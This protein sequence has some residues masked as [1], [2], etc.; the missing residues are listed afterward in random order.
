MVS[1]RIYMNRCTKI[2]VGILAFLLLGASVVAQ[3]GNIE[4]YGPVERKRMTEYGLEIISN[5]SK[6]IHEDKKNV[7]LYKERATKFFRLIEVNFDN[8]SQD[9]Y[10]DKYEADLSWI[11]ELEPT[12]ENYIRRGSF[13]EHRLRIS[14]VPQEIT[15]LYPK[16]EY[17]DRALDDLTKAISITSDSQE[18]MTAYTY[19]SGLYIRRPRKLVSSPKLSEFRKKVDLKKVIEELENAIRS[20][21]R[22]LEESRETSLSANLISIYQESADIAARLGLYE[23]AFRF[24][25][26]GGKYLGPWTPACS[27]LSAWGGL[28]L[29]LNEPEKAIDK[30]RSISLH[31]QSRCMDLYE[32]RGDVYVEMGEYDLALSDY[33]EALSFDPNDPFRREGKVYIKRALLFFKMGKT[34]E[35]LNDLGKALEKEYIAECPQA[36]RIRAEVYL[37]LKKPDLAKRDEQTAAKLKD[38]QNCSSE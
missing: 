17:F 29:K 37:K 27:Y 10:R 8:P 21:Q 9:L 16:N 14:T 4:D 15:E 20:S 25:E 35:A 13:L 18:R 30:F 38:K 36:Y 23:A 33:G 19:L 31:R 32:S 2:S 24:F 28:Y 12:A 22:A 7:S 34:E 6:Q 11:I 5:L 3:P 1:F 26:S